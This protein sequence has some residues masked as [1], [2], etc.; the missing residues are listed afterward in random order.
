M[1]NLIWKIVWKVIC[2]WEKVAFENGLDEQQ[3]QCEEIQLYLQKYK[4]AMKEK[5]IWN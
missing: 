3:E 1:K 2:K 4:K 5:G